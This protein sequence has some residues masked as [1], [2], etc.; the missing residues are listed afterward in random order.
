M[1]DPSSPD[2]TPD[3]VR[4]KLIEGL[5]VMEAVAHDAALHATLAAAAEATADALLSGR[6]LMLAGNGGSAS[7][8]QHLAAEFVC[9]LVDDRPAMRAVAL[10]TNT[11]ILTAVSNDYGFE[12]VFARQIEALGEAGD[13]FLA[14]STSGNSPNVLRALEQCR[15]L[16]VVTIGLTGSSGGK[17]PPLCD[18][19]LRVPSEVTMYIQ[20]AH[21][22]LEHIF[23]LLVERR[24]FAAK[25]V[26]AKS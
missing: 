11:S 22:A 9:R 2:S 18:Y 25:P 21:L 7:D 8:A 10:T 19:C 24:Y 1:S 14:I 3:L 20:Q 26:A 13:V 23:S 17:M 15:D 6:K 4:A 5:G 12:R 16:G